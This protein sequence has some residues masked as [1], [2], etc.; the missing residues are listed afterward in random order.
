MYSRQTHLNVNY[1][2]QEV[3]QKQVLN[4]LRAKNFL[5]R[6]NDFLKTQNPAQQR[7]LEQTTVF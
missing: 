1:N 5:K 7:T 4:L 2:L 3:K 6:R